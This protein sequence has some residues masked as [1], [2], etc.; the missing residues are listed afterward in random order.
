MQ[1]FFKSTVAL[2]MAVLMIAMTAIAANAA[3]DGVQGK[4]YSYA[5]KGDCTVDYGDAVW[6]SSNYTYTHRFTVNGK[7]ATCSWSTNSTPS[8][9]TYKNATKYYLSKSA[10]RAKAFYW[11]YLDNDATISSASAKY[12]NSSKTY[13]QDI[14]NALDDCGGSGAYAFVHSVIDYLQQGTLNP[15]CDDAWNRAVKAFAAKSEYYPNVPAEYEIFYFYP[16]GTAAQSLM[17]WEGAPH[18]Y[19][20][21]IKSSSNTSITNGNSSYSFA[22]IEYYVSKSKTDFDTSGSNYIG[23]IKL[24][25]AGE[26]HS[27][28][29]SRAT[30]RFLPPGTYYVKEGYVPSG[31]SY[32]KN[33]TV[34]TVNVTKDHTTTAPLVLRVSDT[35]KT[36]YGKIVKASTKPEWTNGNPDYS[37]AGIRYSFSTSSTDFNPQGTKYIGYVELDES[38]TGYTENGSRAT[39]RNLVP[40]TYYV[41]ESVIPAGCKYK[42]DKTVYTMTFTFNN[43]KNHLKVL[44]VKD[45]PEGSSS[46]KIIKKSS[47][48][49]ISDGNPLYTL[50]GAEFT[51]YK[52]RPDAENGTNAYTTV[53]TDENGVSSISEIELG[54]YYV[55][56]T[57]AP[58]GFELSNEIKELKADELQEETYEVEFE[59]KP[60]IT[61][62]S[63]LL[64]K[65]SADG[66]ARLGIDGAEYTVNYYNDRYE[67]IED[68]AGVTPTR[69]WVFVTDG[70]GEIA[71]NTD[72]RLSGDDLFYDS[73][74]DSY[75]LPLGTVSIQE[76]KA[77]EKFY[78]DEQVYL[79]QVALDGNTDTVMYN[80]P[81][82]NEESIEY[83]RISGAKTWDDDNDRDGKRP[84]SVTIEL[85]RDNELF[86]SYTMSE[87]TG[88]QYE[89]A[90]LDKG[91]ADINIENHFHEY[92]YEVKEGAVEYYESS[93][94]GM[95]ADPEDKN[96]LICDFMNHYV[97]A[98]VSVDG[99]KSW[100]DY[101]NAMGY[102][103]EKIKVY[104]YRDGTKVD[105]VETGKDQ[106]WAYSF[107]DLYQYHDGGKEYTYTIGEEPVSGYTVKVDG[108][109]LKNTLA[110]GSIN[111][112]KTDS[113]DDPM[114]G[115]S[116]RLYTESG[117]PVGAISKDNTYKFW[118]LTDDEEKATYVT[119][120][121]GT[122]HI[123]ELPI[124]K[125]YFEE[126]DTLLGFIPYGE[127]IPFEITEDSDETLD[128]S[129]EVE[130][131]KIVM[132]ET[133]GSGS[134]MFYIISIT[135]AGLAVSMLCI[136][137]SKTMRGKLS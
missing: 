130:N 31:C 33:D 113:D 63:V 4:Q 16:N 64:K 110:T 127:K 12:D 137:K 66:S 77:P 104:L 32:E 107:K 35:P 82:S 123:E 5:A 52:T 46:A 67:S 8:K 115:V 11:L 121:D 56:E 125:Y 99:T 129:A 59:D 94:G 69:A 70:N 68:L 112:I 75:G 117:K 54:T 119:G 18:G 62:I 65:H 92:Q 53:V 116:F 134:L 105:E 36:C 50:E 51:V 34:Y 111:L 17:S 37:F 81:V 14:L 71:Y 89:F 114:K 49:E 96:H 120:D 131:A 91:Y 109:N 13:Y 22:G 80:Y 42:L 118:E 25:A 73:I 45:E 10:M 15:Y 7:I 47:V 39:L 9:G 98:K 6:V 43:D 90:D 86:D 60:I 78:L 41:K 61:P 101:E 83:V 76:T 29:G 28:D 72:Y 58:Y 3:A 38:G 126:T 26:G 95:A 55:K 128:V 103:P 30:L 20:K 19:I 23:Y 27:K 133:G 124:G 40:G 87:D 102:R 122:I 132:P 100:K 2:L 97:P 24:N 21:V 85:F 79:S 135:L 108:Y 48:P 136:K 93:T 57:K 44:N 74:N 88:W 1:H 106:D 84:K